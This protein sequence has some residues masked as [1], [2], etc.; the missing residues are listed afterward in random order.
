MIRRIV[1]LSILAALIYT[2]RSH[3]KQY[4]KL[5]KTI[6]SITRKAQVHCNKGW[7]STQ[8]FF[9]RVSHYPVVNT[10]LNKIET[11]TSKLGNTRKNKQ[12]QKTQSVT[13]TE[14]N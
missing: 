11:L 4:P 10:T 12:S 6:N 9:K 2:G 1:L 3:L 5:D 7:N 13:F 14:K 8:R